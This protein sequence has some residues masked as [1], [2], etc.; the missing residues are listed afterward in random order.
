[1]IRIHLE[2]SSYLALREEHHAPEMAALVENNRKHLLP[3]FPWAEHYLTEQD[4]LQSIRHY[5]TL[6]TQG[7][8]FYLGLW[9]EGVLA[10][11]AGYIH[12][13]GPPRV[14]TL[15]YWLDQ[16]RQGQGWMSRAC[17]ALLWHGFEVLQFSEVQARSM[18]ANV[19]SGNMLRRLGFEAFGEAPSGLNH[20]PEG[21]HILYR[22][23]KYQWKQR[24]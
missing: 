23:A 9:L 2:G 21:Q 1:M 5:R 12:I 22:L 8:A 10:G 18:Q 19:R 15:V 17:E 13:E 6:C 24:R 4:A 14:G 7:K 16:A 3:W 20:G 11:M